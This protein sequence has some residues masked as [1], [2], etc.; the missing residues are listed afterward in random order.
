ML[1]VRFELEN[2]DKDKIKSFT[3]QA[4]RRYTSWDDNDFN[5]L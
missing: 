5:L 2:M 4:K 3:L 1:L